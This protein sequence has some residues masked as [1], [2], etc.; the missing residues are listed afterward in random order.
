MSWNDRRSAGAAVSF[1]GGTPPPT[2]LVVVLVV[3]FVTFSLRFFEATALVPRLLEL[4]REVWRFGFVWKLGTYLFAAAPTNP[5]WFLLALLIVFWFGRD[6]HRYLGSRGFWR[7][8][9]WAGGGASLAAVVVQI[10]LDVLWPSAAIGVPFQLMQGQHALLAILIAAFATVYANA[11]ILL[12]FVLPIQARWFL[13]LEI[14]FAFMGFLTTKDFA[15]FVGICVAVGITWSLLSGRGLRKL[16]REG[17]LRLERR[18]LEARLR[19]MKSKRG[20]EVLPGGGEKG[21]RDA[22]GGVRKGPWV[23]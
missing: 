16:L 2:D 21:G 22:S 6:V 18:M 23:H 12:F 15:G 4:G 7:L 3:L 14:L 11:T 9:V 13:G 20:F 10:A 19:R 5:F 1:G 17:R 8:I